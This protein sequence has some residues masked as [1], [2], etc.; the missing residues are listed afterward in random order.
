M[1]TFIVLYILGLN[2]CQATGQGNSTQMYYVKLTIEESVIANITKKLTPFVSNTTLT[3]DNLQKTTK[4][5]SIPD[6]TECRCQPGFIWSDKVCQKSSQKCCG[7]GT[8]VF[9]GNSAHMCVSSK[10]V[11]I[12]GVIIMKGPEHLNCLEKKTTKQFKDCNNNLLQEMKKVYSTLTGFDILTITKYRLGSVIAYFEITIADNIRHQDLFE[13]TKCL[14]R[15]L[16]GSLDLESSGVV[17][18]KMPPRS[19]VCH[20][21]QPIISCILQQDLGTQPVWRLK[22][23]NTKYEIFNGTESEV[24][25]ATLETNVTLKN[26]SELWAGEYTCAYLQ[27]FELNT[28]SHK[29][30]AVL[31]V[32]VLP[33]IDITTEPAFPLCGKSTDTPKVRVKCE[34]DSSNE[35]YNVTWS[36]KKI[37]AGPFDDP[38]DV[39]AANA[40]VNCNDSTVTPLLTCTFKNRC[41]E[42]RTASTSVN[43]IYEN[44]QSCAAEGV[45]KETKAGFT[46]VLK[47]TNGVGKRRRKCNR[48]PTEATWEQ[49]VSACVNQEV[50]R[51]LQSA[52]IVDIGLGSLNE[53]AKGVF[54]L[55]ENVTNNSQTINTFSNMNAS[56]QVLLSLSQKLNSINDNPTTNDFLESSSNLLE[57]SLNESWT[58]A[59]EGNISLAERYLDAVENLIQVTNVTRAPKKRNIEVAASSCTQRSCVNKVFDA[60]VVLSTA[61]QTGTVKTAG[62]KE[63]EKYLPCKNDKYMPNSII[64]STTTENKQLGSVEVEISFAL[65]R[66]RPSN[67]RIQCVYWDNNTRGWSQEGCKWKGVSNEGRCTCSHLSTFAILM[68]R[69]PEDIPGLEEVTYVGLSVSVLSLIISLVIEMAIWSTVVKT[70]TSYLRHTAH[71]NISLCLLVADCCFLASSDPKYISEMWCRILVVLKHFCYLSMFFWM[72]S[73]SSMLLHQAMFVFH[74][75][76]KKTYLKLSL[77][78]GYVFP[79]LVVVSTFL[80]YKGGAEGVYFSRDTCW[81]LY[82]GLMKGSIHTFVIPVGIIVFFNTF[83]MLMVIIKLLDMKTEKSMEKEKQAAVTVVRTVILLTPIFGVTWAFGF[84]VMLID[85]T[86]G[87]IAIAVNYVFTLLNAFQ[88]LFILLTTCLGDKQTRDALGNRLKKIAQAST[89]DSTVKLESTSKM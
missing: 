18:I 52:N 22:K 6:G 78:L 69:Y 41:N 5:Q 2:I 45:W 84:A 76:S 40:L 12:S 50:N 74:N 37:F 28:I 64:V 86:S 23:D 13:R 26:V 17:R 70:N 62:F 54:S 67:V 21:D 85:L 73:L 59:D 38:E 75:V 24:T 11:T 82:T 8:C 47:C 30:S 27:K 77:V 89:T 20:Y 87:P 39:Y 31:N 80:S 36:H 58:T 61:K 16:S 63:L 83:A 3:V 29:A 79:L 53:N 4:C 55:L 81:L 35:K 14:S 42:E 34:I 19:P 1:W 66:P 46:A 60:T 48:G 68:S 49:E 56:V 72:F 7:D 10:T 33:N 57:S 25:S 9:A 71:I 15:T 43:V 32:S 51:A 65:L 88:G 44:E